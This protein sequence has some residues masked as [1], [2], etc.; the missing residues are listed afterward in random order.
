MPGSGPA[1]GKGDAMWRSLSVARGDIV[2][3]A[4]ADTTDFQDHYV[5]GTFGPLLADPAIQ[6]CKAAYRRPFTA[7]DR[8]PGFP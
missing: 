3:F 6:F 5:Y 7:T 8:A 1:Q 2:M 4:D